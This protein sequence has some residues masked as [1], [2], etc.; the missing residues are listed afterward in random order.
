MIIPVNASNFVLQNIDINSLNIS[1][2]NYV[3]MIKASWCHF[4][5]QYLPTYEQYSLK[6]NNIAFLTVEKDDNEELLASWKELINPIFEVNGYPTL[7]IYDHQG[8]PIRVVENRS[9]LDMEIVKA[10]L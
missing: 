6:H 9:D 4:C 8:N 7:V 2:D 10:N 3:L 5:T 1:V